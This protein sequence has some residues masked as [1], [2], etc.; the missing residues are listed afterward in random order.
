ML[1]AYALRGLKAGVVAGLAFGLFVVLVASPLVAVA[2]ERAGHH[3]EGGEHGSEHAAH[4]AANGHVAVG[5]LAVPTTVLGTL[6]DLL[7][8]VG[9]GALLGVG[10]GVVYYLL[11]PAIPGAGDVPVFLLGA[12]GLVT[13]S[14]APWLAVPPQPPGVEGASLDVRGLWYGGA[15]LAGAVACLASG[16]CYRRL[17]ASGRD[18]RL[19]ALVAALPLAALL[20]L[21]VVSP[22]ATGSGP[23][24]PFAAA[25]RGVVLAGQV[26]LWLVLT[27]TFARLHRRGLDRESTW[28]AES[29]PVATGD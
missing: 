22:V 2:E 23:S 26:G 29:P 11:E 1:S 4:E 12:A 8:G 20:G 14:G 10:F 3:A 18:S 16:A 28:S 27:T 24:G 13:I 9:W 5:P 19:S 17:T 25:Y 15:L 6:T 7:G 21:A